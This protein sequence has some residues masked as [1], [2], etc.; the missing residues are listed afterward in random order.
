MPPGFTVPLS[1]AESVA[2]VDALVVVTMGGGGVLKLR[3]VPRLVPEGLVAVNVYRL[4]ATG[5]NLSGCAPATPGQ[6]Y[7][8]RQVQLT[9]TQ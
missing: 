5:C 3:I 2:T 1:V 9:L 6:T 7:V 4:T 8:E